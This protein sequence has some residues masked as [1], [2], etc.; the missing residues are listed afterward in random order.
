MLEVTKYRKVINI[1]IKVPLPD[2]SSVSSGIRRDALGR[3]SPLP[4]QLI[5]STKLRSIWIHYKWITALVGDVGRYP[6]HHIG[7][8]KGMQRNR[9]SPALITLKYSRRLILTF[10]LTQVKHVPELLT[11]WT[12]ISN[13]GI[14]SFM[15]MVIECS[16]SSRLTNLL[17]VYAIVIFFC[18][19][20]L[21]APTWS[22]LEL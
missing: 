14:L 2:V 16:I 7:R 6:R 13:S 17:Q 3:R 18:V 15:W 22:K 5:A 12:A 11:S 20:N 9:W 1:C 10:K 21:H 4:G 19:E 8:D